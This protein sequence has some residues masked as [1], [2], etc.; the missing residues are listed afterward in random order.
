MYTCGYE[1]VN[2]GTSDLLACA[3]PRSACELRFNNMALLVD[4]CMAMEG[5]RLWANAKLGS[6]ATA[7]RVKEALGVETAAMAAG[8]VAH[9]MEW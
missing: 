7:N 3:L 9:I 4:G 2:I 6:A 1:H 8:N 5:C